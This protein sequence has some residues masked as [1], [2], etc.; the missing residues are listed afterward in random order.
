MKKELEYY[1][2]KRVGHKPKEGEEVTYR[3]GVYIYATNSKGEV[4]MIFDERSGCWELPGGGLEVGESFLEGGLREF[5]EETGFDA[6]IKGDQPEF[7]DY[8][9]AFYLTKKFHHE[10]NFFY[11]GIVD[12]NQ[13]ASE[14]N[15]DE[16]EDISQ[17]KFF[18]LEDLGKIEDIIHFQKKFLSKYI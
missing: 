14:L 15:L 8:D 16:E 6:I 2:L 4:L 10:I 3:P 13:V 1:D 17:V 9:L 12:E 11:V 18:S 5:K 7:V